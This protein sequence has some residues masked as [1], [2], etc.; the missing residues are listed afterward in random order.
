MAV[1]AG[2]REARTRYEVVRS[3]RPSRSRSR[4]C[5]A[6]SRPAGPTRSG[7][8][9]PP[10]ATRS[11]ATRLRRGPP[12]VPPCRRLFLH[13]TRLAFVHPASGEP[14]AFDSPLPARSDRS[15]RTAGDRVSDPA[16]PRTPCTP[17]IAIVT[18]SDSGIGKATAV[19]LAAAGY[20]VGITLASGRGRRRRHGRR[21]ASAGRRA[22][23][24][25]VDLSKLPKAAGI[26]DDLAG[27]LGGLRVLVNNAGTGEGQPFLEQDFA[28]WR[29]VLAVDLDAP[30]VCAQRAAQL[31]VKAGVARF[32]RQRHL[33]PRTRTAPRGGG[34]L[35]GQ[36]WARA[37]DQDDGRSSSPS[38]ASG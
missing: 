11:S 13:A 23:V 14:L 6:S 12:V 1:S 10:S 20:D 26:I 24:R 5:A 17:L 36:G 2:G 15:A 32:D 8:T 30:F 16:C 3:L 38:T 27:A 35:R 25:R 34:L 7:S 18:G 21:G 29:E 4:C 37:V 19:E 31:M 33:G 28:G 22:E 9:W